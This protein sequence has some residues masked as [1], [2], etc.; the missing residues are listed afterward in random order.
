MKTGLGAR[1][2]RTPRFLL[3]FEDPFLIFLAKS[4]MPA[5]ASPAALYLQLTRA[6]RKEQWELLRQVRCP[7]P[8]PS[9]LSTPTKPTAEVRG[10]LNEHTRVA[11]VYAACQS[12]AAASC[13]AAVA[14]TGGFAAP[15]F[16]P[17]YAAAQSACAAV[18]AGIAGVAVGVAGGSFSAALP[19]LMGAAGLAAVA[20][21]NATA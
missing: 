14:A 12:A 2:L 7:P 20:G 19:A 15:G 5:S 21:R 10:M 8:A 11:A 6:H 17:C 3:I 1:T 4:C 18:Q 13:A 9:S 16:A